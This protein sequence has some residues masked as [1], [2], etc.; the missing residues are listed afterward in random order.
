MKLRFVEFSKKWNAETKKLVTAGSVYVIDGI[1]K[2]EL[3]LYKGIKNVD[4]EDYYR[5]ENGK[6]K[7]FDREFY[8][9]DCCEVKLFERA[10]GTKGFKVVNT[11]VDAL[12]VLAEQTEDPTEK[13][14]LLRES[15]MIKLSG[16]PYKATAVQADAV[17]AD[18]VDEE[19]DEEAEGL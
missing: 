12:Q 8:G 13:A 7:W 4:G 1:T 15:N 19:V 2:E 11:M 18:E 5:E 17:E 6:P 3:A 9:F 16:K 10:D 14:R